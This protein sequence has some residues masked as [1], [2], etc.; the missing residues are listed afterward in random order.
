ME[1]D[2]ETMRKLGLK[3][4]Q[5]QENLA[6]DSFVKIYANNVGVG[7]TNW[8]MTLTFGEIMGKNEKGLPVIEQKVK[9][10]MTREFMK[11]FSNLLIAN[12]KVYEEKYGEINVELAMKISDS[13]NEEEAKS[14]A[15]P[16]KKKG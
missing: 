14:K 11:A 12:I 9:V 4:S 15:K 8:D 7:I 6:S 3:D 5:D 13:V 10:N 2:K 1:L 16:P